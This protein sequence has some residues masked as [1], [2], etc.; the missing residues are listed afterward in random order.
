MIQIIRKALVGLACFLLLGGLSACALDSLVKNPADRGQEAL[1]M[2]IRA[3]RL[4]EFSTAASH[5]TLENRQA[6]LD[7]FGPLEKDLTISD[8]QIKE[9]V[10][11]EDGKRADVVLEMEYFLLPSAAVKTFRFEQTW[12]YFDA[13]NK[14]A[15]YYQITT[16]FPPFPDSP[17]S[18][19]R[20]SGT[21]RKQK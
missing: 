10:V 4:E 11:T 21:T 13:E 15:A 18:S 14:D 9:I 6:F 16:P 7:T 5:M 19:L 20:N 2:Y 12:L 8:V 3:L 1:N 17:R